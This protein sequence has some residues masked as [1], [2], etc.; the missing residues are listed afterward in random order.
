MYDKGAGPAIVVIQPLQGRWQWTQRFLD[1][2]SERYR[3][4]S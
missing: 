2:L 3:V 1:A 4:V